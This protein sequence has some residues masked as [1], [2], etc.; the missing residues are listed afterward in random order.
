MSE[1]IKIEI[2]NSLC[3]FIES[4]VSRLS[5]LHPEYN[6][7][8]H[9]NYIAITGDESISQEDKTEL[10]KEINFQLYRERIYKETLPIRKGFYSDD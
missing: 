5:Y 2:D 9:Q 8:S 10:K 6:F 4:A 7:K 1:L 3:E